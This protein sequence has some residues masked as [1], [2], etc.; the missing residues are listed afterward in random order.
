M[1]KRK[2][3]TSTKNTFKEYTFKKYTTKYIKILP[4][5][6]NANPIVTYK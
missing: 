3:L 2:K 4:H 6:Q 5:K 1:E